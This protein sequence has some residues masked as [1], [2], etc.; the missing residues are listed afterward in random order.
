MSAPTAVVCG[1]GGFGRAG[2]AAALRHGCD[3]RHVF[4][5]ADHPGEV[6]WW[7]SMEALARERGIPVSVDADFKAAAAAEAT[8]ATIR[9]DFLL[10]FYF[11]HMIPS[12][13]LAHARRGC[14]NL[15]GSLLPKFRGR[16][17]INWQLVEGAAEAGLTLHAM[18]RSADAGDIVAQEP[19]AI[20]PDEDAFALTVRM[21]DAAPAFFDRHLPA[22]FAGT[23]SHRPQDHGQA[24]LFG[25]RT[26]A[27]GCIRW[28]GTARAAHDLVRAV[29]FP[30]PGAFTWLDGRKLVIQRARVRAEDGCVA[31]PGTILPGVPGACRGVACGSGILDLLAF[32]DG[33]G[34]PFVPPIGARCMETP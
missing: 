12:R 22:L 9:P 13:I 4:T 8:I 6:V 5:H 14:Y 19:I 26:P 33:Q 31:A 23:A 24:T 28:S 34:H 18:V 7:D 32:S 15:H 25:R 16:A 11:R 1:Y 27:D 2:L 29:A 21:L 17:P 10:S 30:W 20:G 3:V